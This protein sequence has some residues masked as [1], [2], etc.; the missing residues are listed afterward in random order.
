MPTEST[1]E[2]M[3]AH[4]R[5][6][7][8][9]TTP[10]IA[11]S[12]RT[13]VSTSTAGEKARARLP[14]PERKQRKRRSENAGRAKTAADAPESPRRIGAERIQ[15]VPQSLQDPIPDASSDVRSGSGR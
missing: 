3:T 5:Q 1:G 4:A 6:N 8:R 12:T 7:P 2:S 14:L 11:A 15:S 9:P 13:A 10:I